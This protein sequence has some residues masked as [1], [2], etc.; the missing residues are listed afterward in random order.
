MLLNNETV[1]ASKNGKDI[2]PTIKI[3]Q[4]AISFSP[5]TLEF[6][7][8]KDKKLLEFT[9]NVEKNSVYLIV[10]PLKSAYSVGIYDRRARFTHKVLCERIFRI[11][12]AG[13]QSELILKVESPI[14]NKYE[15]FNQY[16][17]TKEA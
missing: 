10:G 17:L 3:T 1:P 6:L 15:G 5:K 14:K 7:G 13:E 12:K 16:P 4:K 8:V 2:R 11:M 9:F